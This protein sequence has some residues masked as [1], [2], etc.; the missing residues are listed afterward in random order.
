MDYTEWKRRKLIKRLTF[1]D[2]TVPDLR[3]ICTDMSKGNTFLRDE[4][5]ELM[6]RLDILGRD[7]DELKK[8][9]EELAYKQVPTV[10]S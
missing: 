1:Y 9:F 4:N 7:Y 3:E 2:V 5:K 6:H 10:R 8:K